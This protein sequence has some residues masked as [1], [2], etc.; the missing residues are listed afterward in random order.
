M[1]TTDETGPG[2]HGNSL[3]YLYGFSVNLK[4]FQNSLLIM[5]ISHSIKKSNPPNPRPVLNCD[6][7]VTEHRAFHLRD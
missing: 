4:L 7:V 6:L 3:G 2:A 5:I 1:L